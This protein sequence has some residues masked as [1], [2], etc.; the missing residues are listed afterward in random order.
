MSSG[1]TRPK[2]ERKSATFALIILFCLFTGVFFFLRSP[3][4]HIREF[5]VEG[6]ERVMRD[7]IVARCAQDSLSIFAFDT[8]KAEELIE[9]SPWIA[10]AEVRRKLPDKVIISVTER[11][12]VAFMPAGDTLWLIDAE[13]RVLGEDDGTWTGLV[14]ITG[15]EVTATPGQFLDKHTYGLGLR[16]LE[17][18]GPVA[19]ERLTEI[20]VQGGEVSLILDDG[21]RVL[22][23]KD[24]GDLAVKATV[25]ESV[26]QDLSRE[27]KMAERIDLRYEKVALKLRLIEPADP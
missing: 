18:L 24:S 10:T 7:E 25:L 8:G 4:F 5:R 22:L 19:A 6:N 11:T 13:A 12:P 26:L 9:F 1:P 20:S 15:P 23:G 17:T 2:R 3:Y 27:G 21:C 16:A 14:A